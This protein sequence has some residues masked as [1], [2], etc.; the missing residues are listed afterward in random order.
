[1]EDGRHLDRD[2]GSRDRLGFHPA[3][4]ALTTDFDF[5]NSPEAKRA[6]AILEDRKLADDSISETFV[7]VGE[8]GSLEDPAFADQ[9]NG[10]ITDLQDLG[11]MCSRRCRQ[12]SR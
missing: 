12:P 5:T 11:P 1:M 3:G 9:V 8:P 10:F 4:P 2:P 7:I 6:Q